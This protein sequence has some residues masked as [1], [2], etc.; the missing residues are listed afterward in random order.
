MKFIRNFKLECLSILDFCSF[1][2]TS[3]FRLLVLVSKANRV[4]TYQNVSYVR[5]W[6]LKKS[7]FWI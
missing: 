4:M 2:K 1:R 3:V 6:N 5:L 7:W